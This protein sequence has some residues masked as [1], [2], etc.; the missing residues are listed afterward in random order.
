MTGRMRIVV[1]MSMV[2]TLA[3]GTVMIVAAAQRGRPR[4]DGRINRQTVLLRDQPTSTDVKRFQPVPGLSGET[5]KNRG[6]YTMTFSGEFS[7]GPVEVRMRGAR[8]EAVVLSNGTP[9]TAGE[10][11]SQSFTFADKAANEGTCSTISAEWRSLDGS[12]ITLEEGSVVVTYRYVGGKRA[13]E[14]GCV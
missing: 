3:I 6:V 10:T 11:W 9:G 4:L 5:I 13:A 2:A 7:G 12:E 8:P 14:F 1:A